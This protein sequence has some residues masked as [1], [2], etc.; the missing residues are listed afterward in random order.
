MTPKGALAR[1]FGLQG[2]CLVDFTFA[3]WRCSLSALPPWLSKPL[4]QLWGRGGGRG[5][6]FFTFRSI[7]VNKEVG[8][9]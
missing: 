7:F 8:H 4:L 3:L 5:A 1:M 6:S 9:F 2:G